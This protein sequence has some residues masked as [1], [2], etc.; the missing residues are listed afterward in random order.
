MK[1]SNNFLRSIIVSVICLNSISF[2]SQGWSKT[3]GSDRDEEGNRVRQTYDGGYIVT[4][5]MYPSDDLNTDLWL[6]KTDKNGNEE[7][8]KNF[9]DEVLE[10]GL[11]VQQTFD[12]GYIISGI[13]SVDNGSHLDVWLI[14]TDSKGNT[15][16]SKTYGGKRN[17]YGNSVIQT[18]DG[19]F[20]VMGSSQ[21]YGKGFYD[22]W[23]L[24]TSAN[25]DSLWSKNYGGIYNDIAFQGIA[26]SEGGFVLAGYTQPQNT[27]NADVWL[28][29][30][31]AKGDTIWTHKYGGK[32]NELVYSVHQTSDNGFILAGYASV[33]I[34]GFDLYLI[35]TD[36]YG[37]TIWTKT[38]GGLS[39]DQGLSVIEVDGSDILVCG[40]TFSTQFGDPDLWLIKTDINGDTLWTKTYGGEYS[41][42]GRS[43][44]ETSDGGYVVLGFTN[45]F[46][47]GRT[48]LWLMHLN[49]LGETPLG[50]SNLELINTYGIKRIYP[51]P[52]STDAI[53][54]YSINYPGSVKL[55]VYDCN[56]RLLEILM[57]EYKN[58]GNYSQNIEFKT[59]KPGIYFCRLLTANSYCVQK[60]I[61]EQ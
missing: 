42:I 34:T 35:K 27:T 2:F 61:I 6:I 52:A 57:D 53:I 37:D 59:Y 50:I 19:G 40:F 16:W 43:I 48:D 36:M 20:I 55:E 31:D 26:T 56:G 51:N 49:S 33:E 38:F 3:F 9:G 21:S 17:E 28:V 24:R 60:F 13:K 44:E 12:K 7:W 1:T 15:I 22:F 32:Y 10:E 41:D 47:N 11:D 45:S 8:S 14:K 18:D 54:E 23:V 46:G 39:N 25:G 30:I 4:G 5:F 29:N 58:N